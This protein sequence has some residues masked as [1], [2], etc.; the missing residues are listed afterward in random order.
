M[1]VLFAT[2]IKIRAPLSSKPSATLN[3][4]RMW[5]YEQALG[6]T[7]SVR[8]GQPVSVYLMTNWRSW[9]CSVAVRTSANRLSLMG[10]ISRMPHTY[11]S[12]S[13]SVVEIPDPTGFRDNASATVNNFPG[14]NSAV[15]LCFIRRSNKRWQRIG[16][17]S[18]SLLLIMGINGLWSVCI[19]NESRPRRYLSNFSLAHTAASNSFSIC[20]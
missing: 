12:T 15:A 3:S 5:W 18:M 20:A 9:S 8:W 19:L 11:A 14:T 13:L 4:F 10:N 2:G 7:S 6:S 16:A 17:V 1:S